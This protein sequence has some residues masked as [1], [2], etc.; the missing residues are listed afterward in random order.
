[1]LY[2]N[3]LRIEELDAKVLP[4]FE[5]YRLKHDVYTYQNITKMYLHMK[6]FD[7]IKKLYKSF[8]EDNITPNKMLLN[9]ILE[10]SIRIDDCDLIYESL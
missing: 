7:M 10:S 8:K 1:M 9:T 2:T 3:C 6:D 5:K 4:L